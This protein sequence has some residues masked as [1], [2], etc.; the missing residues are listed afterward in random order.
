MHVQSRLVRDLAFLALAV[1]SLSACSGEKSPSSQA[2]LAGI[3]VLPASAEPISVPTGLTVRFTAV[4]TFS[5]GT[6]RDVTGDVIWSSSSPAV[7]TVSNAPAGAGTATAVAPGTAE[8]AATDPTSGATS[9]ATVQVLEAQ[10]QELA[11]APVAPTLLVG[12]TLQMQANAILTDDTGAD[13]AASVT[14]TSSDPAVATVT[15]N[16]LVTAVAV[17]TATI[18]AADAVSGLSDGTPVSVTAM[19]AA[20]SFLSL[21]RGSVV[22]GGPVQI[23]GTVMLTSPATELV[24]VSLASSDAAVVSV[25]DSVVLPA[26]AQSA[27]FAVTTSAVARKTAVF[28]TATREDVT[29][30]AKLNVRVAR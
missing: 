23:T 4:G 5:D 14:W 27:T 21:S 18:T 15:P 22:G 11:V 2:H 16:G 9:Y 10:V 24:V 28:L 6:R 8:I 30:T 17:G 13:L 1:A 12:S 7:A 3:Q 20:L 26:G 25:P 19:P 29:K